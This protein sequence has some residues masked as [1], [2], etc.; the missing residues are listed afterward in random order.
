MKYCKLCKEAAN[1]V[2]IIHNVDKH[3]ILVPGYCLRCQEWLFTGLLIRL[4]GM[5]LVIVGLVLVFRREYFVL[6]VGVALFFFGLT[7]PNIVGFV[8]YKVR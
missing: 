6:P 1:E 8:L 5:S 4:I 7:F 3:S 2:D